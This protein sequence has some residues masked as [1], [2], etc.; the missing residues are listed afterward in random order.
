MVEIR[1]ISRSITLSPLSVTL[2]TFL[3]TVWVQ[4]WYAVLGAKADL[5]ACI[6]LQ[7]SGLSL[8]SQLAPYKDL[9][10]RSIMT[11]LSEHRFQRSPSRS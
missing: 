5:M 11:H 2:G 1:L 3:E 6:P 7:L 8:C 4:E 10:C 9:M